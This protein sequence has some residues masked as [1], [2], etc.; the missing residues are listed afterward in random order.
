MNNKEVVEHTLGTLTFNQWI[1]VY[2]DMQLLTNKVLKEY[3]DFVKGR[4]ALPPELANTVKDGFVESC[5]E[6]Q[7]VLPL[8]EEL[9][10]SHIIKK[11][12]ESLQP[13]RGIPATYRM[14]NKPVPNKPS[15]FV[16]N[17]VF[18]V[19]ELLK[20][21]DRFLHETNKVSWV[22][23]ILTAVT[24]KYLEMT[25]E[26]L[27]TLRKSEAL[28]KKMVK[29]QQQSNS[30]TMSDMDKIYVQLFLDVEAFGAQLEKFGI[31]VQTLDPYKQLVTCV[32]KSKEQTE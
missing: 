15:Y 5:H 24:H 27:S 18:P 25:A 22:K 31:D 8:I 7:N 21:A 17:L 19:E 23:N 30:G 14:T 10:T 4:L 9:I 6:L 2:H 20:H 12:V 32:S 1:Y 13:L 29:K 28:I 3:I 11:C 26:L 16:N